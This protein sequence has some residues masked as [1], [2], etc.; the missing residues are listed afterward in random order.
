VEHDAVL[1][2]EGAHARPLFAE[3]HRIDAGTRCDLDESGALLGRSEVSGAEVVVDGARLPF[4]LAVRY[5]EVVIEVAVE[6]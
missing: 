4:L 3:G 6:R 1:E 2:G 5:V